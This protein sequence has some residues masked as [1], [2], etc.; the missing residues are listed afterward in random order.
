MDKETILYIIYRIPALVI[1]IGVL[2]L[3]LIGVLCL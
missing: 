1:T 2:Y 3:M